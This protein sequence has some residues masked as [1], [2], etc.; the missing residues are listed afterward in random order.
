MRSLPGLPD[1]I[2]R[3]LPE[4]VVGTRTTNSHH[5]KSPA[6]GPGSV[7]Q[8]PTILR[9]ER[10]ERILRETGIELGD[11]AGLRDEAL[12]GALQIAGLDLKRLVQ[13][14][15]GRKLLEGGLAFGKGLLRIHG[16]FRRNGREGFRG[17]RLRGEDALDAHPAEF[18]HRLELLD[19]SFSPSA[20][21]GSRLARCRTFGP[22]A[23][24]YAALQH[25]CQARILHSA[26]L[27]INQ[28]FPLV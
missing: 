27:D 6:G 22:G 2:R 26:L 9:G 24:L 21:P 16:G 13:R 1:S 10:L 8:V 20:L 3:R 23:P 15:D 28:Y 17:C 18:L 19:D 25:K 14:L 11:L 7:V 4:K 5:E 12:V